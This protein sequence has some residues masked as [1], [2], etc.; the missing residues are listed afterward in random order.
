VSDNSYTAWNYRPTA[1]FRPGLDL[2]GYTIAAADGDI[3]KVEHAIYEIDSACLVVD[4]GPWILDRKVMLPA[5][6]VERIDTDDHSVSVDR[7]KAPDQGRSRVRPG[8]R[9]RCWLP[10]RRVPHPLARS[11]LTTSLGGGPIAVAGH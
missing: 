6:M 7:T 5:G 1:G 3:G 10:R 8:R 4:T 9:H 11:R 2:V